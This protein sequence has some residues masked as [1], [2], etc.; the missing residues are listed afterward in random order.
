MK[1]DEE[2]QITHFWDLGFSFWYYR[3][4]W[5]SVYFEGVRLLTP[6]FL[7][8]SKDKIS[9]VEEGYDRR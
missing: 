2:L 8:V 5:Q 7:R 1:R 9:D 6:F 4:A 3:P